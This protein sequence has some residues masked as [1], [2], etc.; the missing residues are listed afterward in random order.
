MIQEGCQAYLAHVVDSTQ[1]V[2]E[3]KDIPITCE[4]PDVFPE[5]LPGLP[6]DRET[7]FIDRGDTWSSTSVNS[8]VPSGTI[9]AL[10]IKEATARDTR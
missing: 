1:T 9:R 2:K 10:G 7:E 3:L 8:S 6:P 5:E 4:F